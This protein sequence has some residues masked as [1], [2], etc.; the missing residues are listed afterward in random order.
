MKRILKYLAEAFHGIVSTICGKK[1]K[2]FQQEDPLSETI[3]YQHLAQTNSK[4]VILSSIVS[5]LIGLVIIV[6]SFAT[7]SELM[8]ASRLIMIFCGLLLVAAPV[9]CYMPTMNQLKKRMPAWKAMERY[10]I[11]FWAI[12]EAA[13]FLMVI[14]DFIA[15]KNSQSFYIC[16]FIFMVIPVF[17]S[18]LS[19]LYGGAFFAAIL[20]A[21]LAT[22]IDISLT[23]IYLVFIVVSTLISMLM[24]N[25]YCCLFISERQLNNA[26]ERCR[27]I[28]EKDSLT[29]MLN[30]RGLSKRL[31]E[32]LE[33]GQFE[34]I[35]AIFIDI[36]NFRRYN[37]IFTDQE[38]DECLYNI[39]NCIRIIS[40]TKTDIIS[41]FG[42]DEF[43][44][45]VENTTEYDL[46]A[47]AEQIRRSIETMALPFEN[48]R[49]MTITVGI[50]SLK[51][52]ELTDYSVLLKEAEENLQVAKQ[53]GRNCVGYG[54]RSF[55][56][57][58]Q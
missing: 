15:Y 4:R 20:V 17:D 57:E 26:N 9:V 51:N 14:S 31:I 33:T 3:L 1:I 56:S 24:Y 39:C 11:I 50:S 29:G 28:T 32:I 7:M 53:A 49:I 12:I 27:Q 19:L 22:G 37:Q 54:G 46:V 30:K 43:V 44:V 2:E 5:V 21:A 52:N 47:F 45:V 38:S 16:I 25:S 48:E 34:N 42:G 8:L 41:R 58:K 23:L 6:Y 35:A 10:T 18:K 40:K 55:K 36:D 13:L